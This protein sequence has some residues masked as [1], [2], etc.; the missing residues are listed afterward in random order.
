VATLRDDNTGTTVRRPDMASNDQ[1]QSPFGAPARLVLTMPTAE[2]VERYRAKCGADIEWAFR[3][4]PSI[5]MFEC[6]ATGYQY[7]RPAD[8]AGDERFYQ[9]LASHWK[10]Y[11]RESRWE[12]EQAALQCGAEARV[13]EVGCGR[14]YF[15]RKI[16]DR[17]VSV[18]GVELNTQAAAS[19]VTRAKIHTRPLA[20]L[21]ATH[22][23]SLDVVCSFQVIEHV[24]EPQRF[25]A[26]CAALLKPGGVLMLSAPNHASDENKSLSD[27]FNLPPHHMGHF[28]SDTFARIAPRC[29]FS[30]ERCWTQPIRSSAANPLLRAVSNAWRSLRPGQGLNLL[31]VLRKDAA[32]S[33]P[34]G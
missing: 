24:V 11:Y 26:D 30:F 23:A 13:L 33:L 17:V 3:G 32:Q 5:S 27:P 9:T 18:E 25:I 4:A 1:Q 34:Q 20:E 16:E 10:E 21:L 12:Y 15:L 29:G 8:V 14:G 31:V 2:L 28:S 7:W 19:K 22:R 6:D